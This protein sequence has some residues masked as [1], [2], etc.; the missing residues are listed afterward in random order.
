MCYFIADAHRR[1]VQL[2][3]GIPDRRRPPGSH[4]PH[5]QTRRKIPREPSRKPQGPERRHAPAERGAGQPDPGR[6]PAQ[7]REVPP[8]GRAQQR[9]AGCTDEVPGPAAR[10]QDQ[11][12]GGREGRQ[13]E[14]GGTA[15]DVRKAGVREE[16]E[17]LGSAAAVYQVNRLGS[18]RHFIHPSHWL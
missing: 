15:A 1:P 9:G 6:E 8:A 16:G 14:G 18:Y 11:R 17:T 12:H 10:D 5:R 13:T 4:H 7:A 3:Y 2:L